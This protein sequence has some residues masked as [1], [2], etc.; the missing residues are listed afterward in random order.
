MNDY[1]YAMAMTLKDIS[2]TLKEILEEL[3]KSNDLDEKITTV[4]Q[5]NYRPTTGGKGGPV[6][7]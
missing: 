3:R 4:I 2:K 7:E 1:D 6:P 5:N